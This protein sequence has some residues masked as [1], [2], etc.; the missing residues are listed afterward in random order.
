MNR[1]SRKDSTPP[2]WAVCRQFLCIL[3][4]ALMAALP[5]GTAD[6]GGRFQIFE[7][8]ADMLSDA[9]NGARAGRLGEKGRRAHCREN[10]NSALCSDADSRRQE[11]EGIRS[12]LP[13][14][15]ELPK[16]EMEVGDALPYSADEIRI[17][18]IRK[19]GEKPNFRRPWQY[20]API[21]NPR[22]KK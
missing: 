7:E 21:S 22:K 20:V 3:L 18:D 11:G 2:L 15:P 4:F 10:P 5:A 12:Q 13:E 16:G 17:P 14:L 6:A 1:Q 19:Q 9:V 8:I